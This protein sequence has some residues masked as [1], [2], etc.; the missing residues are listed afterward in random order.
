MTTTSDAPLRILRLAE[1]TAKVGLRKTQI[2]GLMKQGK[3]PKAVE[4]TER[5]VGWLEHEVDAWLRERIAA[6]RPI[7]TSVPGCESRSGTELVMGAHVG[8]HSVAA[9]IHR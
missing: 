5:C 8:A 7:V 6:S 3:F 4:L 2:Y 1:V 9:R